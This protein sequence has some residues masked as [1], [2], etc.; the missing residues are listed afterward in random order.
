MPLAGTVQAPW[1]MGEIQ[2]GAL[3]P[4]G[5][6]A[7]FSR[8]VPDE[9]RPPARSLVPPVAKRKSGLAVAVAVA[10]AVAEADWFIQP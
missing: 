2:G 6:A 1:F 8:W 7:R 3:T 9:L 10:V 4:G 5:S